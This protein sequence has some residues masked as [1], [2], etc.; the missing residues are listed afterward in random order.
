MRPS[1]MLMIPDP[2]SPLSL[3]FAQ[4]HDMCYSAIDLG[5]SGQKLQKE[6]FQSG[7]MAVQESGSM[8]SMFEHDPY[9]LPVT[10]QALLQVTPFS[11]AEVV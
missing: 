11:K 4:Q 5:T 6:I 7:N 3:V 1:S 8:A 2:C 10:H 9:Q